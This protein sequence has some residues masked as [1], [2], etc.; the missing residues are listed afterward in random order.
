M[1]EALKTQ[2]ACK[3]TC[4]ADHQTLP[5]FREPPATFVTNFQGARLIEGLA[6]SHFTA[7]STRQAVPPAQSHARTCVMRRQ[8][9]LVLESLCHSSFTVLSMI[10][11]RS[12]ATSMHFLD[13]T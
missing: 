2:H 9:V 11:P 5:V 1:S 12:S 8:R 10:S 6:V 4:K 7:V 3:Q 13:H